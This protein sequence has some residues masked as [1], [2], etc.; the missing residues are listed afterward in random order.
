MAINLEDYGRKMY[1]QEM[2]VQQY[3]GTLGG[4]LCSGMVNQQEAPASIPKPQEPE[5][6]PVLLLLEP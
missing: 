4:G 2:M 3:L 1:E 5:I 6:N